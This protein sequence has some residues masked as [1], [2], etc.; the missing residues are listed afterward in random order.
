M[1]YGIAGRMGNMKAFTGVLLSRYHHRPLR[2]VD[3]RIDL[4]RPKRA[5]IAQ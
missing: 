1:N 4:N 3:Y 2:L 5:D